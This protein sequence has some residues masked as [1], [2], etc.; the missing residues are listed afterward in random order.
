ME[1]HRPKMTEEM[2][3]FLQ[4][5]LHNYAPACVALSEFRRQIRFR[6]QTVLDEFSTQFA[7]LGLSLV[8]LKPGDAAPD[9]PELNGQTSW[10]GLRKRHRKGLRSAFYVQ[11]NFEEPKRRQVWVGI[12]IYGGKSRAERD[13]L[14]GVLQKQT[15]P[16]SETI[17]E[18][19]SDGS[20]QLSSYCDSDHFHTFDGTFR[21]LI[22]EW[23]GLLAGVGGIQPY[24]S[25][26]DAPRIPMS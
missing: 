18:Q 23:L 14:F 9:G 19:E 26:T 4:E 2:R 16:K 1:S 3:R 22:E 7:E 8:D 13:R 17:L 12:W 11:W 24:L 21:T 15:S 25:T 6:L 20:S 10:I 5:G